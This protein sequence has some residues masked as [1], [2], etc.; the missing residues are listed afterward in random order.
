MFVVS[1]VNPDERYAGKTFED[2]MLEGPLAALD[3]IEQ[4]TGERELN[5]I[6]YCLGGTL[7]ACMLAWL[8]SKGDKRVKSATFF[9]AMIDFTE[10]GEL[11]VFVDE[12]RARQPREE[13]GRSAAISRAPRWPAPS[14]CCAPTT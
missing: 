5:V 1:W 13:D 6:G 3:A 2:Y 11:G 10:P 7:L 9:T 4:A 8:A 12:D 14:T